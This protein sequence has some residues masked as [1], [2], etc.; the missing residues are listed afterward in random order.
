MNITREQAQAIATRG[1]FSPHSVLEVRLA[2]AVI[3][4]YELQGVHNEGRKLMNHTLAAEQILCEHEWPRE[5]IPVEIDTAR[6]E[7]VTNPQPGYA[8]QCV[9]CS[10]YL[11]LHDRQET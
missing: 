11:V 5:G 10:A 9:K 1:Y 8:Y 7:G 4:L 6:G 2:E 3:E